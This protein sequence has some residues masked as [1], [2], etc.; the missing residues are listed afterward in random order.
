[1]S[2]DPF[3]EM[4][5]PK[6]ICLQKN[7]ALNNPEGLI[8]HKTKANKYPFIVITSS[9]TQTLGGHYLLGS[10]LWAK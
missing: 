10:H 5:L 4:M 1:M 3:K 8:F 9:Y 7:L 2:S 6:T